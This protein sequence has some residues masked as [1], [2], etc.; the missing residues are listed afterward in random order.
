MILKR[1]K[2]YII[3]FYF[4]FIFKPLFFKPFSLSV[5]ILQ[6]VDLSRIYFSFLR[7][8]E[9]S[10]RDN[11]LRSD[12]YVLRSWEYSSPVSWLLF[13]RG[14]SVGT[15]IRSRGKGFSK[16]RLSICFP[17]SSV[18]RDRTLRCDRIENFSNGVNI[19]GRLKYYISGLYN[20]T[21]AL[22][23][24]CRFKEIVNIF[25]RIRRL[26]KL[27]RIVRKQRTDSNKLVPRKMSVLQLRESI[28]K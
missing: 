4:I 3:L 17:Y 2:F 16:E 21:K 18:W 13:S 28:A 12:I 25:R 5:A 10:H 23:F 1:K 7:F 27:L 20:V 11:C 15:R 14:L 8:N 6:F 24:I 22:I 9:N 19:V 26:M